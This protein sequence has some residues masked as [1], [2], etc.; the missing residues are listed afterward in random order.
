MQISRQ[1]LRHPP[2]DHVEQPATAAAFTS[3]SK[4]TGTPSSARITGATAACRHFSFGV[5]ITYP[6]VGDERSRWTGPNDPI[7]TARTRGWPRKKA[8]ISVRVPSG[9]RVRNCVSATISSGPL[10]TAQTHHVPPVSTPPYSSV[11]GYE[12][13]IGAHHR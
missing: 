11:I 4:A 3:V 13:R 10:A 7:P 8:T 1:E 6:H 5:S 9:S 12:D 2:P